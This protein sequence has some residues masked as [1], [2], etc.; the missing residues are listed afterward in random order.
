MIIGAGF[1]KSLCAITMG[2]AATWNLS[3]RVKWP[4]APKLELLPC[5]RLENVNLLPLTRCI[6]GLL[7]IKRRFQ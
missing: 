1:S 6:P 7:P 4:A 3:V 5:I 2:T